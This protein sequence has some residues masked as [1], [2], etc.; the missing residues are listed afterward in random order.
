MLNT[1]ERRNVLRAAG[2]AGA[3][4]VA[5]LALTDT[6][7]ADDGSS[8][9]I[10]TWVITHTDNP[11]SP[12]NTGKG[13][14]TLGPGGILQNVEIAPSGQ[15]GGGAWEGLGGGAFEAVFLTGSPGGGGQ[16]D[17]IVEV[18]PTGRVVG[19]RIW[20]TYTVSVSNA[21]T[22]QVLFNGTGKFHGTRLEI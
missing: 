16:P 7:Q 1:V 11:P 12:P 19:D 13:V 2:A 22:G 15:V 5:G 20:G 4:A 21:S 18:K 3:A 6:A 8:A 17:A 14:V 9:V 10:G